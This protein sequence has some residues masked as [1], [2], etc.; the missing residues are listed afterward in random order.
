MKMMRKMLWPNS[1]VL[2]MSFQFFSEGWE[3]TSVCMQACDH[4]NHKIIFVESCQK[5]APL[6][7]D[8][9]QSIQKR[10]DDLTDLNDTFLVAMGNYQTWVMSL[11]FTKPVVMLKP[12]SV[13]NC[14]AIILL[15]MSKEPVRL[16]YP[17]VAQ[18]QQYGGYNT[19]I[20]NNPTMVQSFGG[21]P[22]AQ[23]VPGTV[24]Q[25]PVVVADGMVRYTSMIIIL[26]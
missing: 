20:V 26:Q 14:S 17:G 10:H 18:V 2:I 12:W 3:E 21:Y 15:R 8:K 23:Y 5:M 9:I 13:S 4:K 24:L 1:K 22:T 25:H 6:I 16:T 7:A 19:P 11:V